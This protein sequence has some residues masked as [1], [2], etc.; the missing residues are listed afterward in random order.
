MLTWPWSVTPRG[1]RSA[2]TDSLDS[3]IWRSHGRRGRV[4]SSSAGS[5]CRSSAR[6]RRSRNDGHHRMF[7]L[8]VANL[9]EPKRQGFG[10]ACGRYL[11]VPHAVPVASASAGLLITLKAMGVGPGDE[12]VLPSLTFIATL[13]AVVHCG[14]RPVLAD[15]DP[16]NLGLAPE[17]FARRSPRARRPSSRSIWRGIPAH[18]GDHRLGAVAGGPRARGCR[19]CVRRR[20]ARPATGR[21]R[22]RDRFLVLRD[23]VHHHRR[24]RSDHDRRPG[25]GPPPCAGAQFP[26]HGRQRLAALHRQGPLVLRNRRVRLQAAPR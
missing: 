19:P 9:A 22:R 1:A 16:A 12:V 18:R 25:D 20:G 23:Q 11:G 8:R 21:T 26:R 4:M 10:Q 3:R 5:V 17:A 15:I 6:I 24:R 14:A 2:D 13:G 7:S